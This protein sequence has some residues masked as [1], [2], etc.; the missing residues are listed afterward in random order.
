MP[1][2]SFWEE[3]EAVGYPVEAVGE[4]G[5]GHRRTREQSTRKNAGSEAN[6]GKD[7]FSRRGRF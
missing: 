1:G 2:G 6:V 7:N 3:G 5:Q 4:A